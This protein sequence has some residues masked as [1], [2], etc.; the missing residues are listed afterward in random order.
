ML[1]PDSLYNEG[2]RPLIYSKKEADE[3]R[4]GWMRSGYDVC[5]F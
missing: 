3:F 1:K 2:M 5:Y 4:V